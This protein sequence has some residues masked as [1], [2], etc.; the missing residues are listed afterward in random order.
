M[1][2]KTT[3][4]E[5]P[6]QDAVDLLEAYKR[7]TP[8]EKITHLEKKIL[9]AQAEGEEEYFRYLQNIK[10]LTIHVYKGGVLIMQ[11]GNPKNIPPYV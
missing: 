7:M 5:K 1:E 3:T 6:E 10:N 2:G 4:E 9:Q 11:S 8:E